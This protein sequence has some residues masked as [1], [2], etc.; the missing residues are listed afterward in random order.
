MYALNLCRYFNNVT[1]VSAPIVA[2][3]VDCVVPLTRPTISFVTIWPVCPFLQHNNDGL[4]FIHSLIVITKFNQHHQI[5]FRL[6]RLV[7]DLTTR[8]SA[9]GFIGCMQQLKI[10]DKE[11]DPRVLLSTG[12]TREASLDNCQLV[13]PC[14]RPNACEHGGLCMV[15]EGRVVCDCTG[16]GYTGKNCHF[17]TFRIWVSVGSII[18][19]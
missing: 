6:I 5:R 14:D 8:C 13:D 19:K 7:F 15:D 17:G 11:L 1:L 2:V 10:N 16:T 9:T 18:R 4:P 3:Y 12:I